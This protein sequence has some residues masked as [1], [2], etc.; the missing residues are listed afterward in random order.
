MVS[1]RAQCGP[2]RF[3]AGGRQLCG[4]ANADTVAWC[5]RVQLHGV[6]VWLVVGARKR[7]AATT[8]WVQ[9]GGVQRVVS[10]GSWLARLGRAGWSV[11]RHSWVGSGERAT[12]GHGAEG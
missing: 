6:E 1:V 7:R 9:G 3:C 4:G 8:Y 10:G 11:G 5:R 12:T 2:W